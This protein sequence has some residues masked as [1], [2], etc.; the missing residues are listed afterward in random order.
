MINILSSIKTVGD[1]IINFRQ[2]LKEYSDDPEIGA[3]A[4]I[5]L[6]N[7]ISLLE[8]GTIMSIIREKAANKEKEI[9]LYFED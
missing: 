2:L 4:N 7:N 1:S 9:S 6:D 3:L 8:R 5:L